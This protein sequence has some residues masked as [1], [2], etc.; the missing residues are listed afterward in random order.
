ML[1]YNVIELIICMIQLNMIIVWEAV[2]THFSNIFKYVFVVCYFSDVLRS[3]RQYYDDGN[4]TTI[5]LIFHNVTYKKL[6]AFHH[7]QLLS[8]LFELF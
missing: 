2:K 1:S 5:N 3:C 7:R 6:L 8:I 4:E